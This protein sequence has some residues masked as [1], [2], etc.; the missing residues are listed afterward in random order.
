[1]VT[2]VG[3]TDASADRSRHAPVVRRFQSPSFL[4]PI[5][6]ELGMS[7]T[8]LRAALRS[9]STLTSLAAQNGVPHEQLMSALHEGFAN[10]SRRQAVTS[11]E[12]PDANGHPDERWRM[13]ASLLE[14]SATQVVEALR[15]GASLTELAEAR[16]VPLDA[17]RRVVEPGMLVDLQL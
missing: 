13:A 6:A 4:A 7:V 17:L 2:A 14:L 8:A 12:L 1:M 15:S 11:A 9:G 5:A 10:A 16:E 3:R